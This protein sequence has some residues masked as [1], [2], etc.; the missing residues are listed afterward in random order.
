[1]YTLLLIRHTNKSVYKNMKQ[2]TIRKLA[3]ESRTDGGKWEWKKEK[4]MDKKN[5]FIFYT[6]STTLSVVL[7]CTYSIKIYSSLSLYYIIKLSYLYYRIPTYIIRVGLQHYC[8]SEGCMI[9]FHKFLVLFL[10]F[11]FHNR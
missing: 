1:M 3:N 5:P 2:F 6:F 10:K 8:V 11:I 9:N 7:L 4:N